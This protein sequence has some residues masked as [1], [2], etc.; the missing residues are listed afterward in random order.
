MVCWLVALGLWQGSTTGWE[1]VLGE[2]LTPGQAGNE[3]SW[4]PCTPFEGKSAVTS[5]PSSRPPPTGPP[6]S[7]STVG[8][9]AGL[10]H[11]PLGTFHIQAAAAGTSESHR[12]VL[13]P[14]S[15]SPRGLS[16]WPQS[17]CQEFPGPL[18]FSSSHCLGQVTLPGALPPVVPPPLPL[19]RGRPTGSDPSRGKRLL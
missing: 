7:N 19:T 18:L 6:P 1:H 17:C 11:G 14:L 2:R 5:L 13:Q 16:L 4:G 10:Q 15:C 9:G 8:W 12:E 3:K